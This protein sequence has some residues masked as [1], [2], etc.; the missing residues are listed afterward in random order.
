MRHLTPDHRR[1]RLRTF[2]QRSWRR[3][4]Q[5]AA[6]LVAAPSAERE[7]LR[8]E[9]EFERWFAETCDASRLSEADRR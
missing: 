5:L 8:A 9:L 3:V 1:R 2:G 7:A 4:G 6:E